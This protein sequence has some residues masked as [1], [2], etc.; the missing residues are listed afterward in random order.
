[1]EKY[2]ILLLHL[3]HL[4]YNLFLLITEPKMHWQLKRTLTLENTQFRSFGANENDKGSR[5]TKSFLVAR[6]QRPY[7][8]P[9]GLSGHI[10]WGEFFLELQKKFFI[11]NGQ[12]LTPPPSS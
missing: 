7:H 5:K 9:F 12:A 4:D 11:I 8:P 10:F 1:M 3:P 2:N 6:P